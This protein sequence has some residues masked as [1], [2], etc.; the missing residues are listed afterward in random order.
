MAAIQH[1]VLLP[2]FGRRW[3]RDVQRESAG[4]DLRGLLRRNGSSREA[5]LTAS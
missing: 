2:R 4:E 5:K 1:L 3:H